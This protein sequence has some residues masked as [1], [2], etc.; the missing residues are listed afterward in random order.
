MTSISAVVH[1][2]IWVAVQ[3]LKLSYHFMDISYIMGFPYNSSV[4]YFAFLK[5][6]AGTH[7]YNGDWSVPLNGEAHATC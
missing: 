4:I 6:F 2:V 3:E 7:S 5:S 1:N